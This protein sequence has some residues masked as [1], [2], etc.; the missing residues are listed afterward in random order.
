MENNN[1]ITNVNVWVHKQN[2]NSYW[3]AIRNDNNRIIYFI[4]EKNFRISLYQFKN[5]YF[6]N[7]VYIPLN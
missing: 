5:N 6:P 2:P 4:N 3:K 7:I 1:N